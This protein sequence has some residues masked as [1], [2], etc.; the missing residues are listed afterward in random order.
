MEEETVICRMCL[1]PIFNFICVDCLGDTVHK[2]LD[3]VKPEFSTEFNSF[4]EK[5]LKYIRSEE[6]LEKCVKCKRTIDAVMCPYCYE[7]EVFWWIFNK[8]I[9]LSKIFARLFNFDFLGTGYL[10]NVK[11]RNLEPVVLI[12]SRKI[13]DTNICESCG[14][15]SDDLREENG[16]WLCESCRE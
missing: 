5:L 15:V 2:W 4:H 10:P 3:S 11:T 14:Q 13:S 16:V 8:D 6:N 1:E 9:K 7:K 12:D